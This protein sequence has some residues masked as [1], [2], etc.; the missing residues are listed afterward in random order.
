MRVQRLK[1]HSEYLPDTEPEL[2][3]FGEVQ[4]VWHLWRRRYDLFLRYVRWTTC[5]TKSSDLSVVREP[6]VSKSTASMGAKPA[7]AEDAMYFQIGGVNS[8][9]LAWNFRVLDEDGNEIASV[10]RAFRG[11]GREVGVHMPHL[12]LKITSMTA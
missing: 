6:L 5:V 11:L 7:K 10:D 9:F 4:Q 3:T 12:W 1:D 8:G 2:D